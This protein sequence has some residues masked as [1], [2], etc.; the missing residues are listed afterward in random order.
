MCEI[1]QHM[2]KM[3]SKLGPKHF[4]ARFENLSVSKDPREYNSVSGAHSYKDILL[5]SRVVI[6]D[7][8]FPAFLRVQFDGLRFNSRMSISIW[9]KRVEQ[10][11]K[12]DCFKRISDNRGPWHFKRATQIVK[13]KSEPRYTTL[14]TLE[15]S[16]VPPIQFP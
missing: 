8:H 6:S 11:R 16:N 12:Q 15:I 5:I 7:T 10:T 9:N 4:K 1:C 3:T 2:F 13:E 14:Y